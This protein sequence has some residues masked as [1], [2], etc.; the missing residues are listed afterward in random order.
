VFKGLLKDFRGDYLNAAKTLD[1]AFYVRGRS[2]PTVAVECGYRETYADLRRD[3]AL[4]LEGSEGCIGIVIVIM[5]DTFGDTGTVE[6]GFVEV[7][8]Y[9][10]ELRS[11]QRRGDRFGVYPPPQSRETQ[12]V[13]F[14]IRE[15]L[16]NRFEYEKPDDIQNRDH[17]LPP[18]RLE[19]LRELVDEAAERLVARASGDYNDDAEREW[20]FSRGLGG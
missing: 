5:L 9:N 14:T 2:W 1:A 19:P 10:R 11:A 12:A 6:T 13:R 16:R 7:W 20:S 17:I 4:L 18:L 3:A 15:L 8:E